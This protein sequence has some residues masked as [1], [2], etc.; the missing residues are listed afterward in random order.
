MG[1]LLELLLNTWALKS[2]VQAFRSAD[3]FSGNSQV[4]FLY[5]TFIHNVEKRKFPIFLADNI[6]E[7]VP[8]DYLQELLRCFGKE[9]QSNDALQGADFSDGEYQI[10]EQ[11]SDDNYHGDDGDG[12]V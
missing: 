5:I 8:N 11:D 2:H 10:Y 3:F 9:P 6:G 7:S 12:S 1:C 4:T